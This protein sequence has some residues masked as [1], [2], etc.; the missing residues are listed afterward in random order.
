MRTP[1]RK[2]WG[3]T[4]SRTSTSSHSRLRAT[5][6]RARAWAKAMC[7]WG[8]RTSFKAAV[9]LSS[10]TRKELSSL[11]RVK[12]TIKSTQIHLQINTILTPGGMMQLRRTSLWRMWRG[13]RRREDLSWSWAKELSIME[14]AL[15]WITPTYK[16][17]HD[18]LKENQSKDCTKVCH[19]VGLLR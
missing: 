8:A 11:S 6:W 3:R 13:K 16:C 9:S 10:C 14:T 5:S 1:T 17:L 2:S 15:M 18:R 12:R 19:P 7:Q 4:C